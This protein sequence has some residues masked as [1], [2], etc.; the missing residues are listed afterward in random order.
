MNSWREPAATGFA[1]EGGN[2]PT[3]KGQANKGKGGG[4]DKGKGGG[5]AT[6]S[7]G[8]QGKGGG[9]GG[10]T[11]TGGKGKSHPHTVTFSAETQHGPAGKNNT[12]HPPLTTEH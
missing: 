11:N 3:G 9:K 7:K 10:P 2:P 8:G 4:P 6:G 5:K 12:P 1:Q